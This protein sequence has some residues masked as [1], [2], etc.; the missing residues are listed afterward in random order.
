MIRIMSMLNG[1]ISISVPI[2]PFTIAGLSRSICKQYIFVY[3]WLFMKTK[4]SEVAQSAAWSRNR[5]AVTRS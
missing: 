5:S 2:V 4:S 3:V 1:R